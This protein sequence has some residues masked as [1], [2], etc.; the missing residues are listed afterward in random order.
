MRSITTRADDLR[1]DVLRGGGGVGAADRRRAEV[2]AAAVACDKAGEELRR[3]E[4][5]SLSEGGGVGV[6]AGAPTEVGDDDRRDG[7]TASS[8]VSST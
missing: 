7:D 4:A 5:R 1:P 6:G 8:N 3:C 2:R